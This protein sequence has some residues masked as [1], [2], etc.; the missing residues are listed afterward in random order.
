MTTDYGTSLHVW[1][2]NKRKYQYSVPLGEEGL[3]PLEIRFLH[4]PEKP[5]GFVGCALSSTIFKFELSE[6][7][8]TIPSIVYTLSP[9]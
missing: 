9:A 4:N 7:R 3:I 6:V 2:F 5:V 1:D 8:A